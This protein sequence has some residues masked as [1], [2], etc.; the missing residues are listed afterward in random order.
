MIRLRVFANGAKL[1]RSNSQYHRANGP[2]VTYA[3]GIREWWWYDQSVTEF[4][5]MMLYVQEPAY[6]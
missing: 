5:H 3:S 4:E 1:W 2:A 6:D